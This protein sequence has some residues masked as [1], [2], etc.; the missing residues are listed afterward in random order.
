MAG[1][2]WL[3]VMP[4]SLDGAKVVQ[5]ALAA[6]Q[7]CLTIIRW[8]ARQLPT[9][10]VKVTRGYYA[11]QQ[12]VESRNA[13][14]IGSVPRDARCNHV[15]SVAEQ[16][17][18]LVNIWWL[19]CRCLAENEMGHY[20]PISVPDCRRWEKSCGCIFT[21]LQTSANCI[22]VALRPV[23]IRSLQHYLRLYVAEPPQEIYSIT[24]S[25]FEGRLK[26]GRERNT[27][28]PKERWRLLLQENSGGN[29][30]PSIMVILVGS[31]SAC[32]G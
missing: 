13:S 17:S 12:S 22:E 11:S 30:A 28:L 23:P 4:R 26:I 18:P 1:G 2:N 14:W 27:S 9:V 20:S 16:P 10:T 25:F 7:L 19:R 8:Q 5:R 15:R 6:R 31:G 24:V 21:C 3:R 29:L 32:S